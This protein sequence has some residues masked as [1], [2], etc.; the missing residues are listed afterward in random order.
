LLEDFNSGIGGVVLDGDDHG[1]LG[2]YGFFGGSWLG[3]CL[4][5][6]LGGEGGGDEGE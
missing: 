4:G 3:N 2:A 1:V 6:R 5:S